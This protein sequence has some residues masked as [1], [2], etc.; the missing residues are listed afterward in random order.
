LVF[1]Q[2]DV[3]LHASF[4]ILPTFAAQ[5]FLYH[6]NAL[7]TAKENKHSGSVPGRSH[8]ICMAMLFYLPS[9]S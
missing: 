6:L 3:K 1:F 2:F 4:E 5:A 9:N 8:S 7:S